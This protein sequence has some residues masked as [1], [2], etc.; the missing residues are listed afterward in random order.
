M[1]KRV[2]YHVTKRPDG[3]WNVKKAGGQN[4]SSTHST[5]AE[6][7]AAAKVQAKQQPLGQVVVHGTANKIRDEYTYGKDPFPP[8]G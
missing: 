7:I 3:D 6:A 2:S 8:A 5:Q 4:A 1:G